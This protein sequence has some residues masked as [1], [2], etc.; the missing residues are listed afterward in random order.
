VKNLAVFAGPV[1]ALQ[2]FETTSLWK[3]G[4]AFVAFCL[5][6]GASYAVN[7]IL[8]RKVDAMHP[9]KRDRPVARGAVSPVSAAVFAVLLLVGGVV[10][11]GMLLPATAT[12]LVGVHF[13]LILAYSIALKQRVILDVIIIAIGFVLRASAGAEAVAVVISPWLVICTFCVCM[14]MGFGKRRCELATFTN[15][16]EAHGHRATLVRYT[17]ELLNHLI[18][19][20]GGIAVMTFIL[21]TMDR[22]PEHQPPF[23]KEKLLFTLP[24][25]VYGI[26]RFAMISETGKLHGP[27]D[28]LLKDRPFL[29]TV[30][31][32]AAIA[33][34]IVYAQDFP[35]WRALVGSS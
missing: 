12:L 17:P 35:D 25:V 6:S 21:Y 23:D 3:A 5:V 4:V 32:W 19:V 26:F 14:F 27:T 18:S 16:E 10:L 8:D 34:A 28:I 9:S 2:L 29:I 7:D 22:H 33:V 31:L 1:F 11:S 15:A 13:V 30:L 24:L 20:T